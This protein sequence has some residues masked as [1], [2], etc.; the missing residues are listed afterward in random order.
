MTQ[1]EKQRLSKD[2]CKTCEYYWTDFPLPLEK[3]ICHCDIVD[4]KYNFKPMD[5]YV[6]YPCLECPFDSYVKKK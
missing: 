1:E 5:A 6:S 2:L 4:K 3:I